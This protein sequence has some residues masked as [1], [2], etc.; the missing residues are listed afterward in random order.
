MSGAEDNRQVVVIGSGPAGAM[1]AL[2]LLQRGI[3]V[4]LLESGQTLPRGALVRGFGGTLY[5]KWPVLGQTQRH[6]ASDDPATLWYNDLAPGGLTNYWTSAVPRFAPEDFSEGERLHERY[7]WPLTYDE[8]EPYYTRVEQL[9]VVTAGRERAP[10]LP[11]SHAAYFQRLAPDWSRIALAAEKFGSGL[12]PTPLA[13][14]TPWLVRRHSAPFNSYTDVVLKLK[15]YAHF[16]LLLGAHALRLEWNGASRRVDGIAYF[17]R[18]AG[19]ERRINASAVV[20]GAGPLASTKLLLDAACAD[21]PEGLGNT[22]GLLGRYLHDHVNAWCVIELDQPF[23]RLRRTMYLTR[24]PY[25]DLPPLYATSC[26]IGNASSRDRFLTV[27]PTKTNRFGVVTFGTMVPRE[28]NYVRLDE[29]QTDDFGLPLLDVHIHF[30]EDTKANVTAGQQRLLA[31]LEEAGLRPRIVTDPHPL[32]PGHSVHFGGTVRMSQSPRYG[33][34]N[35]WNRL[36]AVQNVAVVDASSFTTG[37]EKNP[38][39]TVMALSARAA[40]RLA[41]DLVAGGV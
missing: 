10:N 39:L 33:M 31:I 40:D 11:A 26:T 28:S 27:T 7:R 1:A 41:D 13:E 35:A 36:H 16:K 3:P 38:T 2:T 34:L 17:D 29:T 14:G 19:A 37:V 8:L 23:S 30:D 4:T 6:I 9:L 12:V 24:A 21:F 5:R 15:R 18:G 32:V 20:V 25:E 22:E